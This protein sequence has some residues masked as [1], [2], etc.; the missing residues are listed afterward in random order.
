MDLNQVLILNIYDNS[1][2]LAE[3]SHFAA[4]LNF[5]NSLQLNSFQ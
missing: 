3:L 5:L 1:I 4:M 2:F